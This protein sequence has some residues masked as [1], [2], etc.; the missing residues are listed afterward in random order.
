MSEARTGG[1][2]CRVRLTYQDSLTSKDDRERPAVWD[3]VRPARKATACKGLARLQDPPSLLVHS[4][5]PWDVLAGQAVGPQSAGTIPQTRPCHLAAPV[6]VPTPALLRA[7][8]L[9]EWWRVACLPA[10]L[11]LRK[12]FECLWDICQQDIFLHQDCSCC[13]N[14]KGSLKL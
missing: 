4:S 3:S 8:G 7:P 13:F 6:H 5:R 10:R 14:S 9:K 11:V 1:K 12:R 2:G